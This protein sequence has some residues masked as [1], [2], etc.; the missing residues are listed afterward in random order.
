[1]VEKPR[2]VD[3]ARSFLRAALYGDGDV[4]RWFDERL[5]D[6]EVAIRTEIFTT[7]LESAIRDEMNVD[8]DQCP[9]C[10]RPWNG[11]ER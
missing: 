11:G 3:A 4:P 2:D 1:M 5:R 7:K 9:T 8:P 6:F 10:R